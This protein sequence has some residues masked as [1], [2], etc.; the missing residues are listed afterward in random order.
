MKLED[1]WEVMRGQNSIEYYPIVARALGGVNCAILFGQLG[2]LSVE[3]GGGEVY[4]TFEE[5]YHE[6]G[7]NRQEQLRARRQLKELDI[8]EEKESPQGQGIYY[9]IKW[10]KAMEII[11]ERI[12][13]EAEKE[14]RK[15]NEGN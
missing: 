5:L 13:E 4:R 9:Q 3:N 14:K 1:L 11:K 7:L 10:E 8:L 15:E 12:M 2:W 6:T